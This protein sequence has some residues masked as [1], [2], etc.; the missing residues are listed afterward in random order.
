MQYHVKVSESL[1]A[2][3]EIAQVIA[4]DED[5]GNNGRISYRIQDSPLQNIIGIVPATG[6]VYLKQKID[7]ESQDEYIVKVTA[8]D[9]GIPPLSSTATIHVHVVDENDNS[10]QFIR[11][12]A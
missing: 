9:H 7:R 2:E 5:Y 4:L 8:T 3:S 6:V 12:R 10:P 11:V 1:A